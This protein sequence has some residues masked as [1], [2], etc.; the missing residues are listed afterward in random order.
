MPA[1]AAAR[2][3]ARAGDRRG[4]RRSP[5][6][7]TV[8]TNYAFSGIAQYDFDVAGDLRGRRR[9]ARR[10]T[11]DAR[12]P[13]RGR[14]PARRPT[15]DVAVVARRA[16]GSL[17]PTFAGDGS[18][19]LDVT[20]GERRLRRRDRRAAGPPAAGRSARPTPARGY[21][22][23]LPGLLPDGKPDPAF[24]D[25]RRHRSLPGRRASR[26]RRPG[27]DRARRRRPHRDRP[28]ATGRCRRRDTFVAVRE[29]DGSPAGFGDG[30]VRFTGL[31]DERGVDVAWRGARPGRC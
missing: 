21:D 16:D 20:P 30:D 15:S 1:L 17:D 2:R 24:G 11:A 4:A 6:S 29:P 23:V 9:A 27:R 12:P 13:L 8:D 18:L 3:A 25:A 19:A 22:V 5:P 14:R 26:R 28:A 31:G 7:L 10:S